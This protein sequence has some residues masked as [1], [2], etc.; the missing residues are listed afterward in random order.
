MA[1]ASAAYGA[2]SVGDNF[3]VDYDNCDDGA[4]E[5]IDGTLDMTVS[6]FTGDIRN[7]LYDMSMTMIVRAAVHDG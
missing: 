2:L 6:A 7:S 5:V 1:V 4:D 3:L